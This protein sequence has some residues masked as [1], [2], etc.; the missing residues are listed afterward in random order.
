MEY[1]CFGQDFWAERCFSR[2]GEIEHGDKGLL[3]VPHASCLKK[4]SLEEDFVFRFFE[5]A[6]QAIMPG[7]FRFFPRRCYTAISTKAMMPPRA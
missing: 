7:H 1:T 6:W 4:S 2:G 5:M 3:G